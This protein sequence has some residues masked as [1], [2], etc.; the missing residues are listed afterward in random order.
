MGVVDFGL[1]AAEAA[2]TPRFDAYGEKTLYFEAR[3]P[4]PVV[5]EMKRRGWQ[6][7]QSPKPFG[8]V[9]RVYAIQI[10]EDG[11]LIGGVDPGEPGAAVHA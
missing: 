5:S 1:T 8:M 6:V 7:T 4:L 9:G 2:L 10:D 3:F 11:R